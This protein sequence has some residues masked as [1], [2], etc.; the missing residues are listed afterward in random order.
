MPSVTLNINGCEQ[1]IKVTLI[2]KIGQYFNL[3]CLNSPRKKSITLKGA[4]D[5]AEVMEWLQNVC[6]QRI[7][8]SQILTNFDLKNLIDKL[9]CNEII[10]DI[11]VEIS[12]KN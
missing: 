1:L 11:N 8:S 3:Y 9:Q 4:K 12:M 6:D 5:G 2:K 7:I 10:D